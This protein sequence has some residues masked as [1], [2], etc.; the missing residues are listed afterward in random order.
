[1]PIVADLLNDGEA[2]HVVAPDAG[3]ERHAP[4]ARF[5]PVWRTAAETDLIRTFASVVTELGP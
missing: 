2:F 1:V 4:L 5:A 3:A